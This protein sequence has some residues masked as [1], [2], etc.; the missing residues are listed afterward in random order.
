MG[1]PETDLDPGLG[2]VQRFAFELR[3]LRQEAGGITYRQMARQVE[4]SVTTLSRAAKG[5]QLPSLPVALAYVRACGGEDKAWEQR[6][7][8]A[9]TEQARAADLVADETV[10]SPYRGLA[11][12]DVADADLFFGR[13][14]DALA[15]VDLISRGK[16]HIPGETSYALADAAATHT[17]SQAGHRRGRRVVVI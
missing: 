3:K 14:E 9:V 1:H 6:W 8:E 4:V 10:P 2:P 17:D 5:E 15:E 7:R 11:R 16:L 13:D 12:F